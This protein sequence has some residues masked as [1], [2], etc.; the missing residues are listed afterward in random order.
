[1]IDTCQHI[2]DSVA[3]QDEQVIAALMEQDS[4]LNT[5]SQSMNV[6]MENGT[7]YSPVIKVFAIPLIIAVFTIM[8]PLVFAIVNKIDSKYSAKQFIKLFLTHWSVISFG[9]CVLLSIV[10][11]VVYAILRTYVQEIYW[12]IS[13]CTL[14]LLLLVFAVATLFRA[15]QFNN[16]QK[17]LLEIFDR[18]KSGK[19]SEKKFAEFYS[20]CTHIVH[21]AI[22]SDITLLHDFVNKF[23]QEH[24]SLLPLYTEGLYNALIDI[25]ADYK[26]KEDDLEINSA[27]AY[28]FASLV[29]N[30]PYGVS[31]Q[32]TYDALFQILGICNRNEHYSLINAF[33]RRMRYAYYAI[34]KEAKNDKQERANRL[35]LFVLTLNGLLY[36]KGS[37][38]CVEDAINKNYDAVIIGD[39]AIIPPLSNNC[40]DLYLYLCE[41]LMD[42]KEYAYYFYVASDFTSFTNATLLHKYFAGYFAY[43]ISRM[44]QS[45]LVSEDIVKSAYMKEYKIEKGFEA[46]IRNTKDESNKKYIEELK[47]SYYICRNEIIK[48]EKI[49]IKEVEGKITDQVEHKRIYTTLFQIAT[50]V[51]TYMEGAADISNPIMELT[52]VPRAAIVEKRMSQDCNFYEDYDFG[53][54]TIECIMD[55]LADVYN[56]F[57]RIE[58]TIHADEIKNR[59]L[60]LVSKYDYS[61]LTFNVNIPNRVIP[62]G[63]KFSSYFP[64]HCIIAISIPDLPYLEWN[65]SCNIVSINDSESESGVSPNVEMNI[66][67]NM[68]IHYKRKTKIYV[69]KVEVNNN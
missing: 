57:E 11:I 6:L 44:H 17:L 18:S 20:L 48:N 58:E 35:Q 7:D 68:N 3:Q 26:E 31:N 16:A 40:L 55:A 52:K 47:Q 54:R 62:F 23:T 2:V 29:D 51:P 50:G 4:I 41:V 65:K 67:L 61:F 53:S 33:Q 69:L 60:N 42:G 27:L 43:L 49:N 5:I 25:A 12:S 13:L 14:A 32:N 15:I 66:N 39:D 56:T 28:L 36:G 21:Y 8:V 1:M 9:I 34:R 37:L 10:A 59:W 63:K 38:E 30:S 22:V 45:K 19:Y 46:L 24:L 64:S